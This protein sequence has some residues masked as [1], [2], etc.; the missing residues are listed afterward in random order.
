MSMTKCE[1]ALVLSNFHCMSKHDSV[2][3][4]EVRV[5]RW[6]LNCFHTP[7]SLAPRNDVRYS[8]GSQGGKAPEVCKHTH[9]DG[10]V[11]PVW[12][13]CVRCD[14]CGTGRALQLLKAGSGWALYETD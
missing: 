4:W 11:W 6:C 14:W 5:E 9:V 13:V 2:C 1:Q 8:Q 12:F 3:V 10:L 7:V